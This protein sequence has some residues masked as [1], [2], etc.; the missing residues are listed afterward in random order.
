M[1]PGKFQVYEMF[2]YKVS[3]DYNIP[4]CK[5]RRA[6]IELSEDEMNLEILRY[7]KDVL[8]D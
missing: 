3:Q 2:Y 1:K 5:I 8:G 7:C 6:M 4:V